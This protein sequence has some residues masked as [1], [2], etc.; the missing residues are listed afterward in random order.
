MITAMRTYLLTKSALTDLVSTRIYPDALPQNP[1]YPNIALRKI[2][3][4]HGQHLLGSDGGGNVR[5][6]ADCYGATSLA[7]E[8]VKEQVRIA[9]QNHGSNK[10]AHTAMGSVNVSGVIVDDSIDTY[11]PPTDKSDQGNY[12]RS[13]DSLIAHAEATS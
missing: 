4:S 13:I 1:T 8:E 9:M 5:I 7:A 10:G 2:S 6:Q 11:R 12:V 3:G